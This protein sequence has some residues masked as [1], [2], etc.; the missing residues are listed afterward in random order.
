QQ[1]WNQMYGLNP[2]SFTFT[3][4]LGLDDRRWAE[5]TTIT[6]WNFDDQTERLQAAFAE[7]NR[8]I[9]A[10]KGRNPCADF[11]GGLKKAD[12][13]FKDMQKSTAFKWNADYRVAGETTPNLKRTT[14]NPNSAFMD[15]SGSVDTPLSM[16]GKYLTANNIV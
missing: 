6:L 16:D 3:I 10:N 14:V 15:M 11:F 1:G 7:L 4:R 5:T 9:S 13:A 8:R 12:K 2:I